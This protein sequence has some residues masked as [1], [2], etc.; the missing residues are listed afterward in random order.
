MVNV[1]GDSTGGSSPKTDFEVGSTHLVKINTSLSTG[2]KRIQQI[3]SR[4][5]FK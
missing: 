5:D 1:M 4:T 2:P 3:P